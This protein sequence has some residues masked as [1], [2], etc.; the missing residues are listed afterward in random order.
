MV[1]GMVVE[2]EVLKAQ[3]YGLSKLSLPMR[4]NV[5]VCE[6]VVAQKQR[7]LGPCVVRFVLDSV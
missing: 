4:S 3:N 7:F 5:Y 1:K 2:S 6:I